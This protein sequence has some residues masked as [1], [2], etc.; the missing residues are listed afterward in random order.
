MSRGYIIV[1][2]NNSNTDYLH[3]ASI[4]TKSIKRVMPH[5]SV[6]LLTDTVIQDS[7]YDNIIQFPYGDTCRD[8][9][10][11]LA[12]DWQVYDATPYEYTIKLESDMYIPQSIEHWWNVLES[13]DM[14]IS[15]KIRDH[16]GNISTCRYYR[17]SIDK[18]D[19]PDTYNAITYFKKSKTA[20]E[21]FSIV[22]NIFE[23]WNEWKTILRL[24]KN[25]PATTDVVYAIAAK[26]VGVEN[27]T[28]PNFDAMTMVHMKR[29]IYNGHSE[30]WTNELIYEILPDVLRINSFV[31]QYPFHY[32]I[33]N[34]SYKLE[35]H[36]YE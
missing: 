29:G 33:K 10:W 5:A 14:V 36:L 2:Q 9:H 20:Q 31:Q 28:L 8:S 6:S 24:Q 27:T 25:E 23:N 11:K 1:A 16:T 17:D 4:L 34:F 7:L 21:F 35:E 19:L 26:I 30:N 18:N 13:R 32:H 22:R 12:N 15:T 3:C